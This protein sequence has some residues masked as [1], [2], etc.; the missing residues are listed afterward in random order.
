MKR[1]LSILLAC[2][3]VVSAAACSNTTDSK[4]TTAATSTQDK[5]TEKGEETTKDNESKTNEPASEDGFPLVTE[6]T[7]LKVWGYNIPDLDLDS[8]LANN[9]YEEKTGVTIEFDLFSNAD[10]NEAFNLMVA[11]QIY[12]DIIAGGFTTDR[13]NMSVEG[14]LIIPLN[15]YIED[16]VGYKRV[17]EERPD[18]KDLLTA[19]DGNIYTFMYT[20]TGAHIQS[21]YKLWVYQDWLDDL[22]MEM[23]QTTEEYKEMLQA[24]VS[25]DLNN[26]GEAD[27][28]GLVGFR[29]DR[30]SDPLCFLMNPFELYHHDFHHIT[31]DGDI[32]FIA[33]TDGWREG[34]RYMNDLFE[35]GLLLKETYI[36]DPAQFKSLSDRP[37]GETIVGSFSL[38]VNMIVDNTIL[39]W[40]DYV[41]VPPLEGPSGL[42]QSA[43]APSGRFGLCTAITTACEEPELA[44]KWLDW[45][46]TE[47]GTMFYH[48]GVENET[49]TLEDKPSYLG[50]T[51][52]ITTIKTEKRE[53]F[54][55]SFFPYFDSREVRYG[56]TEDESLRNIDNTYVLLSAAEAY[57]PYYK[58]HNLPELVWCDDTDLIT[59]KA[60]YQA[61]FKNYIE[62]S[63]TEFILGTKDIDDDAQWESYKNELEAMGLEDYLSTLKEYYNS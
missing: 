11:S 17:L 18:F 57:E 46:L 54:D 22:D 58:M 10:A 29:N 38:W 56:V 49:Y 47:E 20:D 62:A 19:P 24:F 59:K 5:E 2:A 37:K 9:W 13:V 50:T 26:N 45:F 39:E 53:L 25:T 48:F 16:S 1:I 32:R 34:L 44:F 8:S 14:G 63:Y 52:S 42:R 6:P 40:T 51:P 36:Q 43:A 61:L 30:Y 31:D 21:Q 15:D 27:E 4:D 60:D 28:L 7:T 41:A 55:M 3:F 23:P 33:N 35:S 12:P